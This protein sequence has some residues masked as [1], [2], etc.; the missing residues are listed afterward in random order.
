[1]KK[2]SL[3]FFLIIFITNKI[4]AM[5]KQ[6]NE[7]EI[8]KIESHIK[9]LNIAISHKKNRTSSNTFPVVFLHGS[10]F[11]TQLSFDFKFNN[12]S[13]MDNLAE[14]GFDVYALDFLGYGESDRYPEM[15]I[16]KS[17]KT[18]GRAEEVYKDVD[19]AVDYILKKTGKDKIFLIGHS[20]GG[21][22]AALY[23]SLYPNKID[24]LVL[25]ATITERKMETDREII[26]GSY[27]AL[28]PQQRIDSMLDLTPKGNIPQ[29][30]KD[31]IET[32]GPL[33]KNSDPL[34]RKYNT[35]FVRFPSG[36]SQDV[37]DLLHNKV[38][39]NPKKIKASTLIIR[40]EWDSYPNNNDAYNLFTSL[41]NAA[42]KKYVVIEKG[43]HVMHLE[44]SRFKL[45]DEVLHFLGKQ[46]ATPIKKYPGSI[47]VI[48]EV[49]PNDGKQKEYLDLAAQLKPDLEKIPGFISIER[50]Q[51]FTRTDK[52]LSL[53]F[54]ENEE[55][56]QKWRNMELHRKAQSAGKNFI[57]KDYHLRIGYIIRDYGMFDREEAPND[58]RSYH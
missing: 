22:V 11:P 20:W 7:V 42:S 6:K 12:E 31:I 32:W 28:T 43:T 18:V 23:A 40:G 5:Q 57:F 10:S 41:E 36:P 33:W 56:I 26:I 2:T 39:Y 29:L 3:I 54:W 9:G 34:S 16:E 58:S 52:I 37:E 24:K 49:I 4:A 21:S 27:N 14:N 35:D 51:S 30:E 47:A 48:F 55:A 45:Y 44:K 1:M 50:F 19:K 17:S 8:I 38:Y 53:S 46:N 13:W 25:F 15:E